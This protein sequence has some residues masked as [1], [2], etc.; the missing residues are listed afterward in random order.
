MSASNDN[1]RYE[2]D[3]LNWNTI[4]DTSKLFQPSKGKKSL[5]HEQ[6][7][8][9][10]DNS[11]DDE[12]SNVDLALD[13]DLALDMLSESS[14]VVSDVPLDEFSA[15]T[16]GTSTSVGSPVTHLLND[17]DLEDF[18]AGTRTDLTNMDQDTL[19]LTEFLNNANPASPASGFEIKM[20]D[21]PD[22][23]HVTNLD[24][25]EE[26]EFGISG[27][28]AP[29]G[30]TQ[31]GLK[32]ESQ[33]SAKPKPTRKF[34]KKNAAIDQYSFGRVETD[35][36]NTL[37][38]NVK[39]L[40]VDV[41]KNNPVAPSY[42]PDFNPDDW[43]PEKIKN[44]KYNMIVGDFPVKSRVETQI[45][46][47]LRVFPPPVEPIVHLP[48]DTISKP[49]LQLKTP[50]IPNPNCLMLDTI[51]CC[52]S[53]L[54]QYAN[55]CRG[56][57]NRERKR[58]SRKKVR[59]PVEDA[60]WRAEIERRVIVLNCREVVN[61]SDL[62]DIDVN[63]QQIKSKRLELP[64]RLACYC[65]HHNEKLGFKVFF[66]LKDFQGN[67]LARGSSNPVMITDDHKAGGSSEM[68]SASVSLDNSAA[69]SAH[70]TDAQMGNSTDSDQGD[71]MP[72][73]ETK[74]ITIPVNS[75]KRKNA[76]DLD[77]SGI[78][79][80]LK[81][82]L[83]LTKFENLSSG[84]ST[85]HTSPSSHALSPSAS[86]K[87]EPSTAASSPA[88][89]NDTNHSAVNIESSNPGTI[90]PPSLFSEPSSSAVTVG[91][92]AVPSRSASQ[93]RQL[94]ALTSPTNNN[95]PPANPA[96]HTSESSPFSNFD[97]PLPVIR[98][99]IPGQGPIRGGIEVTL[100]GTGFVNGLIT[101]FGDNRS[102]A[103]H[104]W[105]S[106]TIVTQL[107]PAQ[108][109]GPVK[110]NFEGW[111]SAD[112]P[113]FRYFDDTDRQLVELALQVVGLKMHGRLEDARD[114]ARTIIGTNPACIA[115]L[116]NRI[117]RARTARGMEQALGQ[118]DQDTLESNL[119]ACIQMVQ[120]E[121]STFKSHFDLVNREG[122]SMLHLAALMGLH[123]LC[124]GLIASGVNV[125]KGDINGY[126]PLHFAVLHDRKD[127]AT[128][129][130]RNGADIGLSTYNG[131]SILD[132]CADTEFGEML[133]EEFGYNH[134]EYESD[135]STDSDLSTIDEEYESDSDI[136]T[137]RRS[138]RPSFAADK[139][140]GLSA[141]INDIR[142]NLD[143]F[144]KSAVNNLN[145]SGIYP[146][147]STDIPP[148]R[149][150]EIYPEGS[151]L[152]NLDYSSA[153]I[154]DDSIMRQP[155]PE[156][157]ISADN[158][159]EE[160]EKESVTPSDEQIWEQL[161]IQQRH[162]GND[163][164]LFFFWLPVF[165]FLLV[166][167]SIQATNYID[168]NVESRQYR[169]WIIEVSRGLIGVRNREP[170]AVAEV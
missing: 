158:D 90:F 17:E 96:T 120:Q 114:V 72:C 139:T 126:T 43:A 31:Q 152:P 160:E 48:T 156:K 151:Q 124:I 15:F 128:L 127:V 149:Y 141:Y 133:V 145:L 108:L 1:T 165:I 29:S 148:P 75:K 33:Q 86:L 3:E 65:R 24:I 38:P 35:E 16:S 87:S 169:Q 6:I 102:F 137:T 99:A 113:M 95:T 55:M 111:S 170:R 164:R 4:G 36:V 93:S 94:I 107:P 79:R 100:L 60:H 8:R 142:G 57:I 11:F 92:F 26:P 168:N 116:R 167:V 45:R 103:T 73:Q 34:L 135:A 41:S 80:S 97:G 14:N 143:D 44:L 163:K 84:E 98:R 42:V 69:N 82:I 81:Q 104:C 157:R 123:K 68:A 52:A 47:S 10:E 88:I 53:N 64:I 58:A 70:N 59:L 32:T 115:D 138:K 117:R 125:N 49:K 62:E 119:L 23:N 83:S 37:G 50:F 85:S 56:C 146:T 132:I 122:Q 67:V 71:P 66:V 166:W 109:A 19:G 134:A 110:V 76:D 63:G 91:S 155:R 61:F 51:V 18:A 89:D 9:G 77:Y 136:S 22:S 131:E 25:K 121:K 161:R 112:N 46:I 2:E 130:L 162:F 154:D 140:A 153:A 105:N 30:S 28:S 74:S 27:F 144:L 7:M 118:S 54:R 78:N 150:E 39:N 129:L 106:T 13:A 159:V 101:K 5:I 147:S 20:E 12:P 40:P 21:S